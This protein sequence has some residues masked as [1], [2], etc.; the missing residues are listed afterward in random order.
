MPEQSETHPPIPPI[1]EN[2]KKSIEIIEDSR[3][4]HE[5]WIK[6][7]QEG[8]KTPEQ[9]KVA[10]DIARHQ[11]CIDDYNFVIETLKSKL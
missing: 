10:G 6:A 7:I 11:K 5:L 1:D 3:L 9:I 2:I 4:T 8:R